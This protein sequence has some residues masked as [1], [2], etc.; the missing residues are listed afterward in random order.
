[1]PARSVSRLSAPD[2]ATTRVRHEWLCSGRLWQHVPTCL[3]TLELPHDAGDRG[4]VQPG[5]LAA[6][7]QQR[8]FERRR[9]RGSARQEGSRLRG[10]RRQK[11]PI[12]GNLLIHEHL[13]KVGFKSLKS[14]SCV[15]IHS[16]DGLIVI[17]T[18]YVDDA[19]LLEKYT[20]VGARDGRYP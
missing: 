6:G 3:N 17:S 4:G 12:V 5:V 16:E 13:V 9:H 18:L 10:I 15:Y 14:D 20:V 11:V 2:V 1:M 7:L 8:G 19:L